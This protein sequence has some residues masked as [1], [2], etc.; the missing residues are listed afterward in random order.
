MEK[1]IL[2]GS[3][4]LSKKYF[5]QV[6]KVVQTIQSVGACVHVGCA[7]GADQAIIQAAWAIPAQLQIFAQF[8]PSGVG[9]FS[10]SAVSTVFTAQRRGVPV[11]FLAGGPLSV[12]LRAR[13]FKRSLASVRG[14]CAAV[15]FLAH[16]SKSGSLN[17]AAQAAALG[18][19]VFV[20][21]FGFS[22]QPIALRNL[23]GAW[24]PS[25]FAGA[26]CLQWAPGPSFF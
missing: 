10:G 19:P 20:F 24:R 14:S 16:G 6:T 18:I 8:S 17:T 3:R 1:I 2:G 9:A 15:F 5:P 26:D 23:P 7:I 4:N 12:P 11:R 21:P 25:F 13:L 22:T